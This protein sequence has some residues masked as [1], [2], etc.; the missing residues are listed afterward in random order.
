MK[1]FFGTPIF[2]PILSL[3]YNDGFR[4]EFSL[5]HCCQRLNNVNAGRI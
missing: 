4:A 3:T 5:G 1:S 2:V